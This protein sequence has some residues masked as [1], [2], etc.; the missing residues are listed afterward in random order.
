MLEKV[1]L[2]SLQLDSLAFAVERKLTLT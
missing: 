2:L 1:P